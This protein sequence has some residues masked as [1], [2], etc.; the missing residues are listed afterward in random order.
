MIFVHRV[1]VLD[2]LGGRENWG[3]PPASIGP[4]GTGAI[5][6]QIVG[7]G[8]GRGRCASPCGDM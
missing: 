6:D 1:W 5:M 8:T 2:Q 4:L 3:G 7:S